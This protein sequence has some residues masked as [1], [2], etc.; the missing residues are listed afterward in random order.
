[1][2]SDCRIVLKAPSL[3]V[4][5]TWVRRLREV[6]QVTRGIWVY[7]DQ[8]IY[9]YMMF[10]NFESLFLQET[11]FSAA[12]QQPPRSPA[13][14]P[15]PSSQRSSRWVEFAITYTNFTSITEEEIYHTNFTVTSKTRTQRIW[16]ATHWLHSAAATLQTPIRSVELT[17]NDVILYDASLLQ[18]YTKITLQ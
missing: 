9:L 14:A 3:D 12:L 16:T 15:P 8:S 7:T 1:M 11:Y 2:A 10:N 17:I 4:K 5:Q 18:P 13:R 6:I